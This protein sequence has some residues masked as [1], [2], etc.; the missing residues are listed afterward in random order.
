MKL[1]SGHGKEITLK[2][3]LDEIGN[4][5]NEDLEA[6][7]WENGEEIIFTYTIDGYWSD[8]RQEFIIENI[9][10]TDATSFD[11]NDEEITLNQEQRDALAERIKPH[12]NI[13]DESMPI[14]IINRYSQA[15]V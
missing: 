2:V 3:A 12:F 8:K 15:F 5:Y 4:F 1:Y 14:H 10:I 11:N 9:E 6:S 13:E 7:V